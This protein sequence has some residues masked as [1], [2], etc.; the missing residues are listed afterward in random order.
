M[1]VV[2][3][4]L[5]RPWVVISAAAFLGIFLYQRIR[6]LIQLRHIKGPLLSRVTGIPH[7]RALLSPNCQDWYYDRNLTY[8]ELVVVSPTKLLTS[9]PELWTRMNQDYGYTKSRWY[10]RAVRYDVHNDNLFTQM[11]NVKHD[12]RR[13]MMIRGYSGAENL[14]LETDIEECIVKLLHLIRS[15]YTGSQR[16]PMDLAEKI[17]FFTLDVISTI[18]FGKCFNL[19]N[20]NKDPNGYVKSTHVGL[21]INNRQIAL[22]TWW[23]N[24]LPFFQPKKGT[25]VK[26]TS[27]FKKMR[28]LNAS[29]VAAREVEFREQKEKNGGVV[30]RADMLTSFMRHGLAGKD[31]QTENILQIVAGADTTGGA[32]KGTF[33]Y[34]TTNPRVYKAL[35][36]EIDDAVA[37]G[38][39]PAAPGIITAMQ[40]KG[41]PYLQAVIRESMR[42]FPPVNNPLSRTTPP[43]GDTVTIEGKEVYIPG[44]VCV[45]PSFKAMHRN[46]RVYGDDA[47]VFR[48]ERWI[49]EKD[50]KKLEAMKHEQN[51]AFG[52]GRWLCLG[53]AIALRELGV[54]VFELFRHFD[55]TLVNPEKPFKD[56]TLTGL[57]VT[58]DMWV[59][60]DERK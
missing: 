46:K 1:D 29:M 38:A 55:W 30:P 17:E 42:M 15:R 40:A 50:K 3:R 45:L 12:E 49:D 11:D 16:K 7:I 57:H 23:M 18:G 20:T 35:Q 33:M 21:E 37:S 22:G 14:T 53:K 41:L 19:L 39:A 52:H 13:K 34:V 4:L 10:Y 48:P 26:D 8:G 58:T 25:D 2:V 6:L 9:S 32:L 47:D 51:I 5:L 28:A 44:G 59:Q 24:E 60:V 31:L 36:A 43:A 27:G 54:A 56:C